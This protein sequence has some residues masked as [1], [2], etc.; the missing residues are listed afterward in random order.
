MVL[1][2]V[3]SNVLDNELIHEVLRIRRLK[4]AEGKKAKVAQP[5]S[6]ESPKVTNLIKD[7]ANGVYYASCDLHNAEVVLCNWRSTFGEYPVSTEAFNSK[8]DSREHV[9][10]L[11][12][13]SQYD[14]IVTLVGVAQDYITSTSKKL[15]SLENKLD[16]Y[17]KEKGGNQNERVP[18]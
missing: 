16:I 15:A 9:N 13:V 7:L 1:K 18:S 14:E 10:S 17:F 4:S 8:V 2:M 3:I 6:I 5:D 11:L 12:W